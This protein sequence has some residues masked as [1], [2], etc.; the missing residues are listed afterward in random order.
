MRR[1]D[2]WQPVEHIYWQDRPTAG[3]CFVR[4]KM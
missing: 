4:L 2:N 1:T 3:Y